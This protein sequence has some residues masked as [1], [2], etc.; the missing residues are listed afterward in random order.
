LLVAFRVMSCWCR[1][2]SVKRYTTSSH[3]GFRCMT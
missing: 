2:P 1:M 3:Y